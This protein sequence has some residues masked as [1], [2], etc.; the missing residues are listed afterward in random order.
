M[1]I[2]KQAL[3][4]DEVQI[5]YTT[6]GTSGQTAIVFIHG[7]LSDR[8]IWNHQLR[9]F[10]DQYRT[11]ALDLAGHGE[12]GRNREKWG[13]PEFGSDVLAVIEKEQAQRVVLVG[14]SLGGPVAL[15]AAALIAPRVL[16]VVGVDTFHDLGRRIEAA[17][18]QER[19]EAF[20]RDF[21]GSVHHM[22][23]VLLHPDADPSLVQELER[24]MLRTSPDVVHQMFLSFADYDPNRA[25]QKLRRTPI[26]CINGD[27]FPI[28]VSTMRQSHADFDAVVLPHTGHYPMLECPDLFNSKLREIL[29]VL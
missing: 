24:T 22:L 18:V 6:A 8:K 20:D 2:D 16:A 7:G 9:A 13:I 4:A 1:K 21:A 10:S 29:T 28:D 3:S 23:G 15:E 17:E 26:R 25:L 14:N 12:S 5:A 27:L 19:A 11:I